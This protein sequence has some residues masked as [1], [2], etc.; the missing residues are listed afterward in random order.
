MFS[1]IKR[2]MGRVQ[3][4][5]AEQQQRQDPLVQAIRAEQAQ[6]S[7]RPQRKPQGHRASKAKARSSPRKAQHRK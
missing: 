1:W 5:P 4:Q 6:P 7:S 2:L 3:V